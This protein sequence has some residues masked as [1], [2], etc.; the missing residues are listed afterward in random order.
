MPSKVLHLHIN[1]AV[2]KYINAKLCNAICY[3]VGQVKRSGSF[4]TLPSLSKFKPLINKLIYAAK[5]I[6]KKNEVF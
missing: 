5:C 1:Y 2:Y 4:I 6:E 3:I